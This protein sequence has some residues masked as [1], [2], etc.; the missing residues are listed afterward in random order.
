M[1]FV[2]RAGRKPGKPQLT[3]GKAAIIIFGGYY[4]DNG[5]WAGGRSYAYT[6]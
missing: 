4:T 3:R 2:K 6:A 1:T 5:L